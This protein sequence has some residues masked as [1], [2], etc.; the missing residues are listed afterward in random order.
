VSAR[1]QSWSRPAEPQRALL[2]AALAAALFF[3]AW[4]LLH[5]G[6]F[7]RG[8]ILDTPVYERYGDAIVRGAVPYRDVRIEY[9]PAALP[10][11]L[12]PSLV[13]ARGDLGQYRRMFEAEMAVCGAAAAALVAFL[14]VRDGARP[15][16]LVV[17]A[18]LAAASPL[19]LGSVVLSRYDLWPAVLTVAALAALA[20][21]RERL[22]LGA[23]GAA[24]AAK[25]YP[26]VVVPVALLWIDKRSGRRAALRAL[27]AF[28]AVLAAC[29]VP[30]LALAPGGVWH[31]LTRQVSRPL[32]I[33][34]LGAGFLLVA[35]QLF[36]LRLTVQSSHGSQNLAGTTAETLAAVQ[37]AL[38]VAALLA[39]WV[40]FARRQANWGRLLRASAASVC[41]V[42]AL[43]KVLSP[44]FL[45]WL[46]PLVAL[47]RGRRG[48]AACALLLLA[49]VLTQN[50]FPY[51]Y[52]R[53]V[54]DLDSRASWLVL[55]R[56]LA[57]VALLAL[58]VW[59]ERLSR[60][61][62]AAACTRWR[63]PSPHRTRPPRLRYGRRPRPAAGEPE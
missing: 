52:W 14:L 43:D 26:L 21:R 48:L 25:A 29:V 44:Q 50:W 60:R 10:V 53:L 61:I 54:N 35:H 8:Q 3:G 30:F 22:A 28:A 36:R 15:V 24:A 5:H 18:T 37:S 47:A 33:E 23:L 13:A 20:A 39:V 1:E 32:Q 40:W 31:A 16:R 34:S 9:P 41:A 55:A 7:A 45:V 57:L 27:A 2:A 58:L 42:V 17:G 4:G 49:M 51:R 12:V 56:D 62:R 38:L 11:F 59:P 6:F 63:V 46:V 19:T